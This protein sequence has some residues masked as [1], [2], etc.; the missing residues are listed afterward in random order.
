MEGESL[1]PGVLEQPEQTNQD[2]DDCGW[3]LLMV[4]LVVLPVFYEHKLVWQLQLQALKR[5]V[6]AFALF[7]SQGHALFTS[8]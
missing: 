1:R 6:E 8:P 4:L 3:A 7:P 2:G 5:I